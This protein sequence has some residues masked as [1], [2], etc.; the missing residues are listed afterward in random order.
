MDFLVGKCPCVGASGGSDRPTFESFSEQLLKEFCPSLPE[1]RDFWLYLILLVQTNISNLMN[2]VLEKGWHSLSCSSR[3]TLWKTRGS[4][5]D[6]SLAFCVAIVGHSRANF[7]SADMREADFSGCP[8]N[9]AYMEKAVA[10][11]TNFEGEHLL[12]D[13]LPKDWC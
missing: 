13:L 11:K 9:G 7:T 8:F 5:F 4:F 10:F 12:L 1:T 2:Q 6:T 3:R